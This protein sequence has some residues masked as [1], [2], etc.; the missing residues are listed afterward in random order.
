MTCHSKEIAKR[1]YDTTND[2]HMVDHG[3]LC[4]DCHFRFTD[5]D[6]DHQLAKGTVLD[7]SLSTS[8][9]TMDGGCESCHNNAYP[10]APCPVGAL[11]S[12]T[13]TT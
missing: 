5:T 1:G 4:Q 7:T 11:S 3:M 2:M 12:T 9:D 8:K 13:I 10:I 6:S